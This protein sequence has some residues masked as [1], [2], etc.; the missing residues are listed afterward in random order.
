[1]PVNIG[2]SFVYHLRIKRGIFLKKTVYKRISI[3]TV[4]L[5]IFIMILASDRETEKREN[6]R[7]HRNIA[8]LSI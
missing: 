4:C 1:M 7:K 5:G 2:I 6:P 3:L 8:R